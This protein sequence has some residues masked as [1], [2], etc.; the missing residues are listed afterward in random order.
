MRHVSW[1]FPEDETKG[2]QANSLLLSAAFTGI[3]SKG[4]QH[5]AGQDKQQVTETFFPNYSRKAVD[6]RH[7]V[8]PLKPP[9][10]DCSPLH[11]ETEA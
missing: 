10:E 3:H 7:E 4:F 9:V 8:I 1:K 5:T 11:G 2:L 6:L